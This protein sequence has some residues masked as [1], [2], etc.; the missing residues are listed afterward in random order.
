MSVEALQDAL[1][2]EH[3]ALWCYAMAVAFLPADQL[4]Q[5]RGDATEHRTLRAEVERILDTAG[6]AA[7]SAEPAYAIP[8]PVTDGPS[9]AALA[10]VAESDGLAAWKSVLEHTSD[11]ELRRAAL[12]VLTEATLRCARWRA[13]VGTQPA[14]PVFPGR[15][16]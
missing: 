4:A 8:Q 7:V 11:R 14:I 12:T 2:T 6:V 16:D 10:V 1:A 3:A 5:A 15:R 13:V 9:A